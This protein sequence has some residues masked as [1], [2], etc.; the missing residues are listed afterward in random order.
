MTDDV[1]DEFIGD[2]L[3]L[4]EAQTYAARIIVSELLTRKKYTAG[5]LY[6]ESPGYTTQEPRKVEVFLNGRVL[7]DGDAIDYPQGW[8]EL[9]QVF[10]QL[11]RAE[12]H[13]KF[14]DQT[15]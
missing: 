3:S 1:L 8:D 9:S 11:Q 5:R 15:D 4:V 6:K 14:K 12:I 10:D 7:A 13:I 2:G